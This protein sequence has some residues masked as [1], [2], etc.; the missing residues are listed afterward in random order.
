MQIQLWPEGTFNSFPFC[1]C[2]LFDDVPREEV[3][4]AL[5]DQAERKLSIELYSADGTRCTL[6]EKNIKFSSYIRK[7]RRERLQCHI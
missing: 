7:C 4:R 3:T 1:W 2:Y 6:I 5:E